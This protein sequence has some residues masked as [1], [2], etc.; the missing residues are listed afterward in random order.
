MPI[1]KLKKSININMRAV[2]GVGGVPASEN[3]RARRFGELMETA[4][5]IALALV[6][7]Q[8]FAQIFGVQAEFRFI[9]VLI[10]LVFAV[11]FIGSL[12]LVDD[13]WRYVRFNWMNALIVFLAFPLLPW[14]EAYAI[15]FQSLRLAL[16][17]RF[18]VHFFGTAL[19]ILRR[20]RFGQVLGL[21]ALL[22]VFAGAL[23]A[24]LEH[25]TIGDGIWWA[26]VTVTTVGYGDVVPET[27]HG[28]LFGGAMLL[29]GVLLFS[30]V[31]ANI[32]AFLVGEEQSR[33]EEEI[34]HTVRDTN[35]RVI[36][37]ERAL[38]RHVDALLQRLETIEV[39]SA[40]QLEKSV[41]R[42]AQDIEVLAR[43]QASMLE[44][45]GDEGGRREVERLGADIKR[46]ESAVS[47][48]HQLI[49][50]KKSS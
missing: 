27:E 2:L 37:Q 46:V 4:V 30:L 18:T 3:A 35:E 24:H 12:Y 38:A 42:L 10:W 26:L 23:F 19:E 5:L 44:R 20:N 32:S 6:F 49:E 31:T 13:K 33:I 21:A 11:E 40:E 34:L 16:I 29:I 25:R 50:E 43:N 9:D 48:L 39:R 36:A 8:V 41:E 28:R 22:V 45:L 14:W 17:F 1:Q 7:F 15:I 47:R